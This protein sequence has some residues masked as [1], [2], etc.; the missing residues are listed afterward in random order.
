[1]GPDRVHRLRWAAGPRLRELCVA[2]R[3][4]LSDAQVERAIAATNLLP[5]PAST[6]LAIYCAW[7][8]RGAAGAIAALTVRPGVVATLLAAGAVGVLAALLGAP[9]PH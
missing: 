2:E 6:Q 5:G 3:A 9:I 1:M 8:L 4:W 7:R